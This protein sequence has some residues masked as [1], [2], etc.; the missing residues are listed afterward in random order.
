MVHTRSRGYSQLDVTRRPR[1]NRGVPAVPNTLFPFVVVAAAILAQSPALG[2]FFR[3]DD[4]LHLYQIEDLGY[5]RFVLTPHGGHV[6][7]TTFTVFYLCRVFFD[8]NPNLYYA[9][10]IATHGFN[11]YLLYRIVEAST[12]RS[13]LALAAA[14]VWGTSSLNQASIGWYSVYGHVLAGTWTL[15]FLYG[16]AR[17]A[18]GELALTKATPFVWI[19]YMLGAAT[20]FGTG[21]PVAMLSGPA[22]YLLLPDTPGRARAVRTVSALLLLVPMLYLAIHWAHDSGISDGSSGEAVRLTLAQQ[23][24]YILSSTWIETLSMFVILLAHGTASLLF[25]PLMPLSKMSLAGASWGAYGFGTAILLALGYSI[26]RSDRRVRPQAA[27]YSLLAA[28]CYGIIAVAR[29]NL[30]V[31]TGTSAIEAA[32]LVRYHYLAPALLAG[33]LAFVAAEVRWPIARSWQWVAM[34]AAMLL[35]GA[36]WTASQSVNDQLPLDAGRQFASTIKSLETEIQSRSPGSTVVIENKVFSGMRWRSSTIPGVAGIFLI[37]FPENE[38]HG[39]RI[40]FSESNSERL[41]H[42]KQLGG[43]RLRDLLIAPPRE[44][45]RKISRGGVGGRRTKRLD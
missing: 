41:A 7:P 9:L 26:W 16:V 34:L 27:A 37:R 21:I 3:A 4:Y 28:G 29:S 42:W 44:G 43:R 24:D 39:R 5:W 32:V 18:A 30:Y 35:L 25:G 14:F 20:S 6:I 33:L 45:R 38:V 13:G 40:Y 19:G 10:A 15:L 36:N 17:V 2:H 11:V 8:L 31:Y 22:L 23:F 1:S 12:R